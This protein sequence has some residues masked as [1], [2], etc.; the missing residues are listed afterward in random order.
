MIWIILL[1]ATGTLV[2]L[3]GAVGGVY[4]SLKMPPMDDVWWVI[5]HVWLPVLQQLVFALLCFA[6]AAG[7]KQLQR[8]DNR[9][10]KHS[11]L[12]RQ[13]FQPTNPPYAPPG[14]SVSDPTIQHRPV[15]VAP[16]APEWDELPDPVPLGGGLDK[17]LARRQ[18]SGTANITDM[19]DDFYN[20]RLIRDRRNDVKSESSPDVAQ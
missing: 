18:R 12:F 20:Q 16:V 7:L 5:Y 11:W 19:Y 9:G 6:A 10:R 2:L 4:E 1:R 13:V 14:A 8:I 3:V 15:D 17:R